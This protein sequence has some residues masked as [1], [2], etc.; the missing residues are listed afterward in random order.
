MHA[1]KLPLRPPRRRE[2]ARAAFANFDRC[3]PPFIVRFLRFLGI[4]YP[5]KTAIWPLIRSPMT[6]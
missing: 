6:S 2:H 1:W 3:D 5:S 4:L